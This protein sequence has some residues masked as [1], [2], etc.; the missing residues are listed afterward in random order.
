MSLPP[1]INPALNRIAATVYPDYRTVTLTLIEGVN[2]FIGKVPMWKAGQWLENN[3]PRLEPQLRQ[4][5]HDAQRVIVLEDEN[6]HLRQRINT[7][8]AMVVPF[9]DG[10]KV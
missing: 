4:A 9:T 8:E 7:L 5:H 2:S 10:G 3:W 1:L 6:Q